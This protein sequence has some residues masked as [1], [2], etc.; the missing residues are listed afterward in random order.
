MKNIKFIEDAQLS[1]ISG[2][3]T[4]LLDNN[5]SDPLVTAPDSTLAVF[6]EVNTKIGGNGSAD[7]H[8]PGIPGVDIIPL[9]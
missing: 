3:I 5:G 4:Y 9:F 1:D 7:D 8:E 2:G 6:G